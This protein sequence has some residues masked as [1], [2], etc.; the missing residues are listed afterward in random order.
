MARRE[1]L[2]KHVEER[3]LLVW[4]LFTTLLPSQLIEKFIWGLHFRVL[5]YV[6]IMV[7]TMPV[8]KLT[9]HWGSRYKLI[10]CH[11]TTG[12]R[13]LTGNCMC[14]QNL[15]AYTAV[16]PLQSR[17]Y[18]LILPKQFLCE[19]IF[20]Y[21]SLW[22]PFSSKFPQWMASVRD[23]PRAT[24]IVVR[25]TVCTPR[26][27]RFSSQPTTP[28]NSTFRDLMSF[29]GLHRHQTHRSMYS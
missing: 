2:M 7:E 27:P 23:T 28:C 8:D 26:V 16:L 5:N 15:K 10:S 17:L 6:T 24:L 1:N 3:S 22:G 21:S 29:S 19:P 9:W 13:E 25:R 20:K 18:F 4:L 11:T 12:Y 14:F